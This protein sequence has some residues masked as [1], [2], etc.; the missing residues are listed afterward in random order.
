MEDCDREALLQ[1]IDALAVA[2]AMRSIPMVL[3]PLLTTDLT[4]RQL[5]TL[6]LI[7]TTEEGAT[8]GI[9]AETFGVSLASMSK[10]L[11]RLIAQGLALRST[12]AKDQRVRRVHATPLGRAVVRQ[13]MA[14]RP[15]L[16]EDVLGRLNVNDLRALEQGMRAV[17]NGLRD[18][19]ET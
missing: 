12:D 19:R 3:E 2:I 13:L 16:G 8:G 14:S 7:V 17:S 6:S 9:L 1:S 18:L 10:V 11:D 4:I 5:K 15:E